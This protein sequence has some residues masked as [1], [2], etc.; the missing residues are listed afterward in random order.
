MELFPQ[1]EAELRS[2]GIHR[3]YDLFH[4]LR[5]MADQAHQRGDEQELQKIYAYAEWASR[6][7]AKD[8]WNPA[9][10]AF[11]EHIVE[12]PAT[13][14]RVIPWLSPYVIRRHWDLWETSLSGDSWIRLKPMLE[15]RLRE[16][17]ES[18]GPGW[19]W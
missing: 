9:G 6:Q 1:L 11:Y 14:T 4:Q 17:G 13:M 19:E 10:V 16:A 12:N 5:V 2:N 15:D 18:D 8:L 7:R 3:P